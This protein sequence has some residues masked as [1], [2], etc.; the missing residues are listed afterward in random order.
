MEGSGLTKEQYKRANR[1]AYIVMMVVFCYMSI[2]FV[3]AIINAGSNARVLI[4]L[5]ISVIAI[6]LSTTSFITKRDSKACCVV[7]MASAATT[8]AAVAV[9]NS[10]AGTYVYAFPIVVA[11]LVY[12]NVRLMVF[13]NAV[14][15]ISNVVRIMVKFDASDSE[16]M[17]EAFISM[18]IILLVTVAAVAMAKVLA[19]FNRENI[20]AITEKVEAQ[21]AA[22]VKMHEVADAI[23]ENFENT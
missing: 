6:V 14:V 9:L 16:F 12:M 7:I 1:M 22:N 8:Y 11:A 23:T 17:S 15:I 13:G 18:F 10:T 21:L 4:Q 20:D 3:G 5:V 19:E 2:T